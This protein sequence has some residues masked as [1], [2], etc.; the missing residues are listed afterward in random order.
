[1]TERVCPPGLNLN[2][3]LMNLKAELVAAEENKCYFNYKKSP[4]TCIHPDGLHP[5]LFVVLSTL[6]RLDQWE[7]RAAV[8]CG[9]RRDTSC[10]IQ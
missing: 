10:D 6:T 7:E 1:M 2:V 8:E 5:I 9:E 3:L 4:F